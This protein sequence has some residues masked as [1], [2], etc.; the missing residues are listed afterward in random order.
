MYDNDAPHVDPEVFELGVPVL[1]ICYG[2]QVSRIAHI[3]G[4][5]QLI[6]LTGDGMVNEGQGHSVRSPRIWIRPAAGGYQRK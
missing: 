1:G 5:L 6:R 2:L 3:V 4:V